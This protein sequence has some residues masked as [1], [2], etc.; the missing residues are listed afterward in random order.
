VF[1]GPAQG[2]IPS[3]K[4]YPRTLRKGTAGWAFLPADHGLD[5]RLR[6]CGE[7]HVL[8]YLRCWGCCAFCPTHD[9]QESPSCPAGLQRRRTSP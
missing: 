4:M 1:I 8:W 3:R 5:R 2:G 7:T 6:S 9:G